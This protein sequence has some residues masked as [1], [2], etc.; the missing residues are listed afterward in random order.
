MGEDQGVA[1]GLT[2]PVL[3]DT[4]ADDE[5]L[6][7]AEQLCVKTEAQ[8]LESVS[9]ASVTSLDISA[10]IV[11]TSYCTARAWALDE[12][13]KMI[14]DLPDFDADTV[15]GQCNDFLAQ[16]IDAI[17]AAYVT[18]AETAVPALTAL[19]QNPD[20]TAAAQY[21]SFFSVCY[22][23]S[24]AQGL[25]DASLS[26]AAL[27]VGSGFS[28]YGELVGEQI[29]LGLGTEQS[30]TNAATWLEWTA[31]ALDSNAEGLVMPFEGYDHAPLLRA[32][33]KV[34]PSLT[35]TAQTLAT[36][37]Q[38]EVPAA[39]NQLVVPVLMAP[40]QNAQRLLDSAVARKAFGQSFDLIYGMSQTDAL[41]ACVD[42]EALSALIG[43][44]TCH[45]LALAAQDWGQADAFAAKVEAAR[46]L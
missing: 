35:E 45:A 37:N 5:P 15:Q 20:A 19:L 9:L 32:V 39:S 33:A 2:A 4:A 14:A 23:L 1:A 3:G 16:Q 7:L 10:E 34:A 26:Y 6:P 8:G 29:A 41:Q 17:A 25:Y 18:P 28:A 12:V 43:L 38:T 27:M 22:G 46:G 21:R 44:S 30:G 24:E 40:N 31:A 13:D 36:K 42:D 11:S